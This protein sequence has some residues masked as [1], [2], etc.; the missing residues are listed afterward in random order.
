[1]SFKVFN[2]WDEAWDQQKAQLLVTSLR[3]P[4]STLRWARQQCTHPGACFKYNQTRHWATNCPSPHLP[5]GPYTQHSQ[6]GHWKDDCSSLSL[7]DRSVSH[8]HSQ[9]SEGLTD[10][11]GLAAEDWHG[12][13]TLAHFKITSEESR[14]TVQ[15]AGGAQSPPWCYPTFQ[16][17]FILHRS[18]WWGVDGLHQT[19]RKDSFI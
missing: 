3:L 9:Q 2:N 8:S 16:V 11:L 4:P 15:V 19:K 12:L 14:V 17:G 10:L 18:P 5:Q 6:N 13:G 1:M 7:Q